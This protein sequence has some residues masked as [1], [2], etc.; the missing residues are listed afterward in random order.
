MKCSEA[1]Q[2]NKLP[3]NIKA[4]PNCATCI[5][6]LDDGSCN[7]ISCQICLK[8]FCWLCGKEASEIHFWSPSGCTYFG[9]NRWN[10][11]QTNLLSTL[12]SLDRST[13]RSTRDNICSLCHFNRTPDPS[14][15]S[16]NKQTCMG[17]PCGEVHSYPNCSHTYGYLGTVDLYYIYYFSRSPDVFVFLPGHAYLSVQERPLLSLQRFS[18]RTRRDFMKTPA[19]LNS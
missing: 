1:K 3:K 19:C 6:K 17:I 4:C 16:P 9:Y 10:R 12:H 5:E 15:V 14:R 7:L 18:K 8:K 11:K 13:D 2:Q